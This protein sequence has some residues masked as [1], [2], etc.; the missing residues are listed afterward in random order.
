MSTASIKRV[1]HSYDNTTE[2]GY[3]KANKANG[4]AFLSSFWPDVSDVAKEA[5]YELFEL[6]EDDQEVAELPHMQDDKEY[7]TREHNYQSNKWAHYPVIAEDIRVQPTAVA[8]KKRNTYWK[9][10]LKLKHLDQEFKQVDNDYKSPSLLTEQELK[11]IMY[12]AA[13]NQFEQNP[14]LAMLLL[15]TEGQNLTEVPGRTAS[16]WAGGPKGQNALGHILEQVRDEL[17]IA[18]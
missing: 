2:D 9:N 18:S 10:R 7:R 11:Q 14:V 8:A 3:F 17:L 1:K 4:Y 15:S 16:M 5:V 12:T 13:T 6:D